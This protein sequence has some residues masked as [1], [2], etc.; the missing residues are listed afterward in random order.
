MAQLK[1]FINLDAFR[2]LKTLNIQPQ[3]DYYYNTNET[4]PS[5]EH[6]FAQQS[7][8]NIQHPNI[9]IDII[10]PMCILHHLQSEEI[11]IS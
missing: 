6:I 2:T 5:H 10:R 9:S 4:Q 7:T 11:V 3:N 8:V 1:H